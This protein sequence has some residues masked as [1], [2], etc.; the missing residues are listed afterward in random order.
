[1]IDFCLRLM[2]QRHLDHLLIRFG[3]AKQRVN[4]VM[5][6]LNDTLQCLS[7]GVAVSFPPTPDGPF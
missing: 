7:R 4:A 6:K 3:A 5:S 2:Q 1:M